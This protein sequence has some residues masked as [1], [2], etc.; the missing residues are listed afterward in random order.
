ML[1]IRNVFDGPWIKALTVQNRLHLKHETAY[2]WLKASSDSKVS[3]RGR[4]VFPADR[5]WKLYFTMRHRM[6]GYEIQY[7]DLSHLI[8]EEARRCGLD[9]ITRPRWRIWPK[10]VSKA[11]SAGGGTGE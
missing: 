9:T 10:P 8:A 2:R 3:L 4:L 6:P 5:L 7:P 11:G 1:K